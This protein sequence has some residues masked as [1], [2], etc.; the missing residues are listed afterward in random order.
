MKGRLNA[1]FL[2]LIND[3]HESRKINLYDIILSDVFDVICLTMYD[4]DTM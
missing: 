1:N 2:K 4:F 3:I